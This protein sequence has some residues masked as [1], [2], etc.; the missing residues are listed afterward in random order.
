MYAELSKPVIVH[1]SCVHVAVSAANESCAVRDTRNT[2]PEL[3]TCAAPPTVASGEAESIWTTTVAP[4][5][6]PF[7]MDNCGT[8]LGADPPPP[9]ACAN[10]PSAR[11]EAVWQAWAQKV[12]RDTASVG[13][14][15]GFSLL[16]MS[17]LSVARRRR[18]KVSKRHARL[19]IYAFPGFE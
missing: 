1:V 12:R 10:D 19:N 6:L 11:H 3:R 7:T 4:L 16:D 13:F 9:H 2:P 18:G 15:A 8:L 5:T 17:V 14:F